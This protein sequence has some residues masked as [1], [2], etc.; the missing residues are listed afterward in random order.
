MRTNLIEM[1]LQALRVDLE[2]YYTKGNV[3]A[4]KRALRSLKAIKK[5]TLEIRE[6]LR[7]NMK[8]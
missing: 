5:V 3:S 7:N 4:A 1:H 6:D 8:K 2:K